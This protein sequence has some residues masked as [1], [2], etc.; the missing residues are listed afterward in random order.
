MG[1]VARGWALGTTGRCIRVV[2]GQARAVTR[3]RAACSEG[4]IDVAVVPG[5]D[6]PEAAAP[7]RCSTR[8]HPPPYLRN[9]RVDDLESPLLP[10][11]PGA[12]PQR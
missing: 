10:I 8:R 6:R 4:A 11:D 7:T 5:E 3:G 12:A 9:R 2:T 1:D